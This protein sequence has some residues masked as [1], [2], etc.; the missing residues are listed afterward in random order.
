MMKI[1]K[2]I[3]ITSFAVLGIVSC[4]SQNQKNSIN[5]LYPVASI[6]DQLR[7]RTIGKD[8]QP[9]PCCTDKSGQPVFGYIDK[10]GKLIL[11]LQF[12]YAGEFKGGLAPVE[13]RENM[14]SKYGYINTQGEFVIQPQFWNAQK[15]QD[16]SG[17]LLAL[18]NS[19]GKY[20]FI[21]NSGN[22]AIPPQFD[23][24]SNFSPEY[25][26]TRVSTYLPKLA[27]VKVGD[28]WGF[29]DSSGNYIVN[30]QYD[31][32]GN[33]SEGL[34]LVKIGDK[35]GYID[36]SGKMVIAP[37]FS[38]TVKQPFVQY[39]EIVELSD[40]SPFPWVIFSMSLARVKVII[41]RPALTE[42]P[43]IT[44][45]GSY[46]SFSGNGTTKSKYGYIDR[47]GKYVIEP[48]FDEAKDFSYD[49]LAPVGFAQDITVLSEV[50]QT[51]ITG[52]EERDKAIS[53][54]E[55]NKPRIS[56][57]GPI[58]VVKW[59]LINEMGKIVVNPIFDNIENFSEGLAVASVGIGNFSTYDYIDKTGKYVIE[60]KFARCDSFRNGIAYVKPQ[61]AESINVQG[62]PFD[63]KLVI[64]KTGKIIFTY[65]SPNN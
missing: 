19:G 16:V 45:S 13:V 12:Y 29:I 32:A 6:G 14:T 58:R 63:R 15:F 31:A 27:K 36:V 60:P 9:I 22:F 2:I 10:T 33:F 37:Q 34:A 51:G 4:G 50:P 28:K 7:P 21:D 8:G 53:E 17:K 3:L 62:V 23:F 41:D 52:D 5:A 56:E 44:K 43:R 18:V 59:G 47:T 48:Q 39:G 57:G 1:V 42:S 20:G 49:G 24:A 35:C 11:N 61:N 40:F 46:G 54:E 26:F 65:Y 38:C 30:P 55:K 64:D 25:N